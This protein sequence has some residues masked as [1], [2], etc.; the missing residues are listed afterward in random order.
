MALFPAADLGRQVIAIVG[1]IRHSHEAAQAHR[2]ALHALSKVCDTLSARSGFELTFDC[3]VDRAS[4]N[5]S[6]YLLLQK[7]IFPFC[8][9]NVCLRTRYLCACIHHPLLFKTDSAGDIKRIY[10]F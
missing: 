5:L 1:A 10:V 2:E 4:P 7:Q 3:C 8:L 6:C 9:C